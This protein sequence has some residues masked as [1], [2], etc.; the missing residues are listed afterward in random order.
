MS[1]RTF[2]VTKE[3]GRYVIR[4]GDGANY[5]SYSAKAEAEQ[6]VIFWTEYYA[7]PMVF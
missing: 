3:N 5:G 2:H 7:A 6:V 1:E 4:D